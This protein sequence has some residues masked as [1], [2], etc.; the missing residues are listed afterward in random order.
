M[1]FWVLTGSPGSWFSATSDKTW[2][3]TKRFK[4][5]WK[6]VSKGDVLIFYATNPVKGVIG[7]GKVKK[8]FKDKTPLVPEELLENKIIYPYKI[9]FKIIHMLPHAFWE[10]DKVSIKDL[11]V[12]Y[13]GQINYLTDKETIKELLERIDAS[14][15]T[16]MVKLTRKRF[17]RVREKIKKVRKRP[18]PNLKQGLI[19]F[20]RPNS[21][22]MIT[23]L[24]LAALFIPIFYKLYFNVFVITVLK[25]S[26]GTVTDLPM[27]YPQAIQEMNSIAPFYNIL[28]PFVPF[29][30]SEHRFIGIQYFILL[31]IYW[32][33]L[34][35]LIVFVFSRPVVFHRK[36]KKVKLIEFR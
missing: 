14:L 13:F 33:L 31:P 22:K 12:V 20:F 7:I 9:K 23:F 16:K 32:Y 18:R 11:K 25:V 3:V 34:S 29:S 36:R 5:I 4:A 17:H 2:G 35:C 19:G 1:K 27:D 26:V 15:Q 21:Y 28:S 30:T 6:K 8:R 10:R 24:I